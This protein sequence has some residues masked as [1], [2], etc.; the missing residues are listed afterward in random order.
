VATSASS[1]NNKMKQDQQLLVN[2]KANHLK[3]D[4]FKLP[5]YNDKNEAVFTNNNESW[6]GKKQ[7]H[8]G[9]SVIMR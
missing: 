6:D 1:S 3:V 8:N 5:L 4:S 2:I 7:K 9:T